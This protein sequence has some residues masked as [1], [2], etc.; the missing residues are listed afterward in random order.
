[1]KSKTLIYAA[2]AV[3][4]V[5]CVGAW[6]VA[7]AASPWAQEEF[8]KALE[9]RFASEVEIESL[10]V[11]VFPSLRAVGTNMVFRHKGRTDVP[12]LF[13]IDRFTAT[14]SLPALLVGRVSLL[15]LEGLHIT[16]A[17][18]NNAQQDD[19]G[20]QAGDEGAR[21]EGNEK[22]GGEAASIE[23]EDEQPQS[24]PV[25]SDTE[26][27]EDD[28]AGP[29]FV[30]STIVADGTHLEILPKEEWKKPLTFDLFKLTLHDA[31]ADSAMQFDSVMTNPKPPGDIVT[32]GKFGP[33][34]KEHPR[35]TP[36]S[37]EYTFTNADLSVF[38]GIS[39]I[40]SSEGAY[41]GVL[42][43]IT[44]EG[45]TD[46]PDF[47][48]SGNPVHLKTNYH[49][50]VDGT[51]GDTYLEPVEAT[52]LQS[53][54][55][56]RGKVAGVPEKKGKAVELNVTVNEARVEDMVAI[57]VPL[58]GE[59]PLSGPI[60]FTT[61]FYLPPEDVDVVE[62]LQLDGQF[63]V[64]ESTFA[65]KVQ[66]KVD[67]LSMKA[68]GKPEQEPVKE[69]SADF[70]GEFHMA[71]GTISFPRIEFAVPG[72][73]VNLMGGYA[74]R[75]KELDF[76]GHLLMDAKISETTTGVKAFFLKLADPFFRD[77]GRTSIPI[78]IG[79]TVKEPDFGL[80]IGGAKKVGEADKKK[81]P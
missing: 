61:K 62:R 34:H 52:F 13:E 12:P 54:V 22:A 29:G 25:D 32:S 3:I 30:V 48:A 70:E 59:P 75:E 50:V 44:V 20:E 10:D 23:P 7:K 5:V 69:A 14:S 21:Q 81:K 63:G 79:G 43:R 77:K 71:N 47:K 2:I 80:A 17:R 67:D 19:S 73:N 11:Q 33:W 35:R 27:D 39:G 24:E 53:K 65:S 76:E 26:D 57:A 68:Q 64:E 9:K 41:D 18:E 74:L 56:A 46:V 37:G 6:L 31:G 58:E 8:V 40:L 42:E 60:Q 15:E 49:A 36:V 51:S 78:K 28:S 1:M 66:N 72:A 45:W 16:V 55:I 4:V 38:K